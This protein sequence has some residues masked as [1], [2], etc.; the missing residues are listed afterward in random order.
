MPAQGRHRTAR[1]M[2]GFVATMN[3]PAMGALL[4]TAEAAKLLDV[5]LPYVVMLCDA[6]QL[7]ELLTEGGHRRI[8]SSAVDAYLAARAKENEGTHSPR[9]AGVEARLYDHPDSHY[10]TRRP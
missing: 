5:S 2:R 10:R 1:V 3:E 6:G 7:G 4:T 9:E 8:W